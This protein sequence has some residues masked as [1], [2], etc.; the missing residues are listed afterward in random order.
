[1]TENERRELEEE[2][3][4]LKK[5]IGQYEFSKRHNMQPVSVQF[6]AGAKEQREA[7]NAADRVR[8]E[9]I[10]RRLKGE[11]PI[12]EGQNEFVYE[13]ETSSGFSRGKSL[14]YRRN[15]APID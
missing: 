13:G 12:E 8:L 1:M 10:E 4:S 7:E 15:F 9:Q 3:E 2:R 14:P 5:K 6:V 11:L